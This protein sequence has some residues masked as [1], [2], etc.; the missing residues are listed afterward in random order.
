MI[1]FPLFCMKSFVSIFLSEHINFQGEWNVNWCY[2][3]AGL[4]FLKFKKKK[5]KNQNKPNWVSCFYL[6]FSV[7]HWGGIKIK[8]LSYGS[9]FLQLIYPRRPVPSIICPDRKA[10]SSFSP[11]PRNNIQNYFL[12]KPQPPHPSHWANTQ[13]QPFVVRLY[14]HTRAPLTPP[15]SEMCP[16]NTILCPLFSKVTVCVGPT[17]NKNA[18]LSTVVTH[19][20]ESSVKKNLSWPRYSVEHWEPRDL[21]CTRFQHLYFRDEEAEY[22]CKL[23]FL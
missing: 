21:T 16:L 12:G 11:G 10:Y 23:S 13:T 17:G 3:Q 19:S 22:F 8:W 6:W 2:T 15:K 14:K 5:K 1:A 20:K 9:S 18:Y 4:S 7:P